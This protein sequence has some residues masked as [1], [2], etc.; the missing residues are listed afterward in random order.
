MVKRSG[1]IRERRAVDG[2]LRS[3]LEWPYMYIFPYGFRSPVSSMVEIFAV[4]FLP[5][6]PQSLLPYQGAGTR[7]KDYSTAHILCQVEPHLNNRDNQLIPPHLSTAS[8]AKWSPSINCTVRILES[9]VIRTTT[10]L[11]IFSTCNPGT[12]TCDILLCVCRRGLFV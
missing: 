4:P 12:C 8:R 5:L 9:F 1:S 3:H 7:T 10:Q 6:D 2:K 11:P